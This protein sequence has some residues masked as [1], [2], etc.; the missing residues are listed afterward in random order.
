MYLL[1]ACNL[2][3]IVTQLCIYTVVHIY[4]LVYIYTYTL[5][6]IHSTVEVVAIIIRNPAGRTSQSAEQSLAENSPGSRK[7]DRQ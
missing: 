5:V 4:V 1:L 6:Y 2:L 7:S 3:R